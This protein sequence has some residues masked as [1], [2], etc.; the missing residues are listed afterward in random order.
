MHEWA[1]A[2]G[3][4]STA[5]RMAKEA[6]LEQ[7]TEVIIKIGELQQ[8]DHEILRLALDQQRTAI[9]KKAKFTFESVP[10]KMVCR[11]CGE[12]WT[13]TPGDLGHDISEAIHFVPEI[14]HAY[15]K[16]PK[17]GSPDFEITEGRGVWLASIKG[18]E[19]HG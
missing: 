12:K 10:A 4:V 13:L 3:V 7:I 1:L 11:V 14:A 2:E 18:G 17:C 9:T 16:C 8:V 6:R 15:V 19:K 5:T